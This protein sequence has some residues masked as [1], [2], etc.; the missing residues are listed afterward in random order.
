VYR[1]ADASPR[2]TTDFEKELHFSIAN[3]VR[4]AYD[5]DAEDHG[6]MAST[7]MSKGRRNHGELEMSL[8]NVSSNFI[9][10]Q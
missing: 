10:Q 9:H 1:R 7:W 8:K 3:C 5:V 2:D 4:A 6:G